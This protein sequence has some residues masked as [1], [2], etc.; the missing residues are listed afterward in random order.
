VLHLVYSRFTA[1]TTRFSVTHCVYYTP[2]T[3][4]TLHL[5]I[6]TAVCHILLHL[7]FIPST[8]YILLFAVHLLHT[9]P[10]FYYGLSPHCSSLCHC[11][12]TLTCLSHRS[13]SH[14][15]LPF[16]TQTLFWVVHCTVPYV[17]PRSP[18]N[19]ARHV[20]VCARK[21]SSNNTC[22]TRCTGA[23]HFL[24]SVHGWD[25]LPL[26]RAHSRFT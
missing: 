2:F 4:L 16:S 25:R 5:Y 9:F 10:R 3:T 21:N 1:F 13:T 8:F 19:H 24:D 26:P 15:C 23:C 11:R 20:T 7:A 17:L 14:C 12:L 18:H 6:P 22:I